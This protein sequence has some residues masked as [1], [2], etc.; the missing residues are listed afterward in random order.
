MAGGAATG[1]GISDDGGNSTQPALAIGPNNASVVVWT[2]F[3]GDIEVH[4][5]RYQPCTPSWYN[6]H[7]QRPAA[8]TPTADLNWVFLPTV[9]HI[10]QSYFA[11]PLEL[12]PNNSMLQANGPIC[13]GYDYRGLPNDRYDVFTL[14]A[15]AGLATVELINHV[16]TGVQ[17]QLHHQTITPSPIALD[18]NGADGYRIE[19]S[20]APAGRY[21]VVISTQTPDPG[22]TARYTL[23]PTFNMSR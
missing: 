21:Y 6:L 22:T 13:S 4:S 23:T 16:G 5:R 20:N 7:D 11:G 15:E 17:L 12:E 2:D 18:Y 8:A 1:G 10:L 14:D 19:L 3:D 9:V